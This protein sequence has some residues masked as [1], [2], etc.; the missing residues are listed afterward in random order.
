MLDDILE[1]LGG[2]KE[3]AAF[4]GC[5]APAISNWKARGIP[6]GRWVD[7]VKMAKARKVELDLGDVEAAHRA[8]KGAA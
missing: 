2:E 6:K 5:T 8:I 3:V 7:L 4:M 1:R